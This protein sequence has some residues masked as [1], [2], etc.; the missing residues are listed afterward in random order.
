MD[1]PYIP[2]G[3]R[4][5]ELE[6]FR[7]AKNLNLNDNILLTLLKET[8]KH[9][10]FFLGFDCRARMRKSQIFNILWCWDTHTHACTRF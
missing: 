6:F 2:L 8:S 7:S 10:Y 4:L 3:V 9:K 5:L 1:C